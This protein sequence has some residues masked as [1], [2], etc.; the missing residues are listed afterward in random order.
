M[1]PLSLQKTK[2]NR[3]LIS[4]AL[5]TLLSTESF[6]SD[7]VQDKEVQLTKEN[8]IKL[9]DRTEYEK[10]I[11]L[12][13]DLL[14]NGGYKDSVDEEVLINCDQLY[15]LIPE[16][17]RNKESLKAIYEL[18]EHFGYNFW[19]H[20]S[21]YLRSNSEKTNVCTLVGKCDFSER[22]DLI[23]VLNEIFW[24]LGGNDK[25]IRNLR[26]SF[27]ADFQKMYKN[28]LVLKLHTM[29][30]LI[31]VILNDR[32]D[33][34][35][36]SNLVGRL[37]ENAQKYPLEQFKIFVSQLLSLFEKV[38]SE[39]GHGNFFISMEE[40]VKID[41]DGLQLTQVIELILPLLKEIKKDSKAK[42]IPATLKV[43]KSERTDVIK[44]SLAFKDLESLP[45]IIGYISQVSQSDRANFVKDVKELQEKLQV[46]D[47]GTLFIVGGF[48]KLSEK[49]RKY[50]IKR[51][52]QI[53]E[54]HKIDHYSY[55]EL[56]PLL[57]NME[58]EEW[59]N[60]FPYALKIMS[61]FKIE[62]SLESMREIP[63]QNREPSIKRYKQLIEQWTQLTKRE[64]IFSGLNDSLFSA[65]SKFPEE[66]WKTHFSKMLPYLAK[67]IE[68]SGIISVFETFKNIEEMQLG[69]LAE[70]LD[71]I[72]CIKESFKDS[73]WP[74]FPITAGL[75]IDEIKEMPH[76]I[77]V[78]IADVKDNEEIIRMF[79]VAS[80]IPAKNR[81]KALKFAAPYLETFNFKTNVRERSSFIEGLRGLNLET[82]EKDFEAVKGILLKLKKNHI[83]FTVQLK[84]NFATDDF[85]DVVKVLDLLNINF[86]D[87]MHLQPLLAKFSSI[88]GQD[89]RN[90]SNL[91]KDLLLLIK[92]SDAKFG[93]L[94]AFS[95]VKPEQRENVLSFCSPLFKQFHY[96]HEEMVRSVAAIPEEER[97]DYLER[98]AK[99]LKAERD[100]YLYADVLT[101]LYSMD[102]Y[103]TKTTTEVLDKYIGFLKSFDYRGSSGLNFDFNKPETTPSDVIGRHKIRQY[104]MTVLGKLPLDML[105]KSTDALN[106]LRDSNTIKFNAV[107]VSPIEI[108]S[109]LK[110]QKII[111]VDDLVEQWRKLLRTNSD[112]TR[113]KSLVD[114]ITMNYYW[115]ALLESDEIVQEAIRTGINLE[116][117]TDPL[118]P[119]KIFERLQ[120]KRSET[121]KWENIQP[122]VEVFEGLSVCYNPSF[123][124]NDLPQ[125]GLTFGNLPKHSLTF[126]DD[127][128]ETMD[129]RVAKD[130]LVK[131]KIKEITTCD[132]AEL[133]TA[134]LA[135]GTLQR[136]LSTSGASDSR[137]PVITARFIAIISYLETLSNEKS[138]SDVF[139]PREEG[140][141]R[142][143][144]SIQGCPNGKSEGINSYYLNILPVKYRYS[145]TIPYGD[146]DIDYL[147][148][149]NEVT[150]I[151]LEEVEKMFSGQNDLM[152]SITGIKHKDEVMQA[153]HQAGY[154]RNRIGYI[155][156]LPDELLFDAHTP[157]LYVKLV[158]L[159]KQ[160]ALQEF[161]KFFTPHGFIHRIMDKYFLDEE[162]AIQ[163]L[164][165]MDILSIKGEK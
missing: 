60:T 89:L 14:L 102:L 42:I 109:F 23:K 110:S 26:A 163:L 123:L 58:E 103:G 156:G 118:N 68:A 160:E 112:K 98:A 5:V 108:V 96:G 25:D 86:T 67:H 20:L 18:S 115:F 122:T 95:S 27:I 17:Q 92:N 119:Y 56:I 132:Y 49:Q 19:D 76:L 55:Y 121:I 72:Y 48:S 158:E 130:P 106:Q 150:A 151:L 134:A 83:N 37:A 105:D 61:S 46:D 164:A 148:S 97:K 159:S 120:K 63:I 11:D 126:L 157:M 52:Y 66:T 13:A 114:F 81:L 70:S 93:L 100:G 162:G 50:V 165:K 9:P 34:H 84:R 128:I 28:D 30:P 16:T 135:D 24:P 145:S 152:K 131:S 59:S 91:L 78:M 69:E 137:V 116:N 2:H 54:H 33:Y 29:V 21:Y 153:A 138:G 7:K 142:M 10:K 90:L 85:P 36:P 64:K 117:S 139:S 1:N 6:S 79:E 39:D 133:K 3:L 77:K 62:S 31:K 149:K 65:V 113:V 12:M 87:G 4:T 35:M 71:K 161:F 53:S 141:L 40:A 45:E 111:V 82:F 57:A 136:L 144:T 22:L 44:H 94:R 125:Y 124:K 51:I 147:K 43:Q 88:P 15:G 80:T 47:D 74:I 32:K 38:K 8:V 154:L 99:L 155:V 146:D 73:Y 129:T 41:P 101:V 140:F 107:H 143:L 127:C 75:T 104:F